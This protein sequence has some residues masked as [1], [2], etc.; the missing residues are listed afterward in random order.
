LTSR[1]FLLSC[2]FFQAEDGIRDFHV[3]GVQTCALPIS[4]IVTKMSL[5]QS[6]HAQRSTPNAQRIYCRSGISAAMPANGGFNN[7]NRDKNVTPTIRA[8]PTL[9]EF[10]VGAA[11]LPRMPAN[12]GPININAVKAGLTTRIVTKMSLLQSVHAQRS[13]PNAQRIYCRSGISA[14]NARQRRAYR[15]ES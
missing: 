3:T 1:R 10:T 15:P 5:L 13:T 8:R 2:F 11:F 4:R 12:G 6:G 14:A 7:P 9:N